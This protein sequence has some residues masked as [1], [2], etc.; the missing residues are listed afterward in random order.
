MM[1]QGFTTL[2]A[3]PTTVL[4]TEA[5]VETTVP[6]TDAAVDTAV[7][8]A[9]KTEHPIKGQLHNASANAL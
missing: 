1:D 6:A 2:T 5:V 4:A 3:P 8:A 9:E 7:P